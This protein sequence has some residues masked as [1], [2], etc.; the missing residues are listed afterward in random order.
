MPWPEIMTKP[1]ICAQTI[2]PI[3]ISN[4]LLLG[5]AGLLL[6]FYIIQANNIA[7]DKYNIKILSEKLTSLNEVKTSLEAQR[8][9]IDNP[10]ELMEFAQSRNMVEAKNITYLFENGNVALRQ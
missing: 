10:S 4:I 9:E 6:S 5:I 2:D 3:L 8:A 7:A 1:V